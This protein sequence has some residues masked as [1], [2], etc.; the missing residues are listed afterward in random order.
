MK[1]AAAF[2]LENE[3]KYFMRDSQL[4][5]EWF[6]A[7]APDLAKLLETIVHEYRKAKTTI[8]RNRRIAWHIPEESLNDLLE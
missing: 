6:D 5:G 1:T 8:T 7:T 2:E 4:K 3:I